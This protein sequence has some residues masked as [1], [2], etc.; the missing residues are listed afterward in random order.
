M[1][2]GAGARWSCVEADSL[3]DTDPLIVVI[4]VTVGAC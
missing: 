4:T 1:S 3:Q 2:R